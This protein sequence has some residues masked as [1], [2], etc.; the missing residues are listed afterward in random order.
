MPKV[1]FR[2]LFA[3]VART[4]LVVAGVLL[5]LTLGLGFAR[6]IADAAAGELPVDTVLALAVFGAIGNLEIVMP[7]SVLLAVL[8]TLGRLCR[9]NEMA[10][11]LASGASLRTVYRPFFVLGIVVAV[12]AGTSSIFFAPKAEREMQQLGAAGATAVLDSVA[13]GRFTTFLD[14]DAAFYA[15]RRDSDDELRDVFIRVVHNDREGQSTQTVVT[16]DRARTQTDPD[17]GRVTLVL[18][19]GWRYEGVPGHAD[20]RVVKFAEHGVQLAPA[21]DA[22]ALK[23]DAQ[24]FATLIASD[25]PE[26]ITEWQTR[27]SVPIS[28]LILTL[29]ALPIGRVPP[30]SGRYGRVIVGILFYVIYVNAVHLAGVA[31]ENGTIPGVIGVWWVHALV[32]ALAVVLVMREQGVF[33]RRRASAGAAS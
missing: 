4:W 31:V 7:V 28:I 5:F 6:F 16:A 18:D 8:L 12:I 25:D 32:L 20:Y 24:S 21:R 29:L 17:S 30:R 10:A 3:E 9:D 11:L 2:Y 22:S 26:A 1:I 13:P 19:D 27:L 23:V 14:G 15:A 33:V